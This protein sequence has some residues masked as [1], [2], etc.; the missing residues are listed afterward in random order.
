MKITKIKNSHGKKRQPFPRIPFVKVYI[1]KSEINR[2]CRDLGMK[3]RAP[4]HLKEIK[5]RG[6][7]GF[8]HLIPTMKAIINYFERRK[9]YNESLG[10]G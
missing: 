10:R 8:H 5:V 7:I 9:F 2:I 4:N 1:S 3:C 6:S